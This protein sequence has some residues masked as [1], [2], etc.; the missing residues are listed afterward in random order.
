MTDAPD[1]GPNNRRPERERLLLDLGADLRSVRSE[2]SSL[3]NDIRE[4]AGVV[5]EAMPRLEDLETSLAEVKGTVEALTEEEP[6]PGN[7]PI[8]WPALPAEDAEREWD[9]L[10]EWV[11]D[12]LVPWLQITRGQLPDIWPHYRRAVFELFWLRTC[13]RQAYKN[14]AHPTAAA[15]WHTR[16]L[17][18]ALDNVLKAMPSDWQDRIEPARQQQPTAPPPPAPGTPAPGQPGYP[19]GGAEPWKQHTPHPAQLAAQASPTQS[20]QRTRPAQQG[21][22]HYSYEG[23]REQLATREH[24][25]E[26]FQD[27]KARDLA[28]RREREQ[29]QAEEDRRHFEQATTSTDAPY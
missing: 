7:P 12:T 14:K 5:S 24:W 6:E 1:A 18:A 22:G 11:G 10:A 8:E 19:T 29:R 4:T 28:W 23:W 25:D 13:Y 26:A 20:A 21:G 3:R 17:D 9:S 15:E 2:V 16:W 27:A